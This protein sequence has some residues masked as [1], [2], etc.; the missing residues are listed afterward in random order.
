VSETLFLT[1]YNNTMVLLDTSATPAKRTELY[2]TSDASLRPIYAMPVAARTPPPIIAENTYQGERWYPE[3]RPAT[4]QI[5]NVY[6]TDSYGKLPDGVKIKSLRIVQILPKTTPLFNQP[7]LGYSS[8]N[9]AKMALGT[10]PVEDDGSVFFEA[11]IGKEIMFQVLDDKGMAVQTM[12]SGTYL[13]PGENMTCVGCHEDKLAAPPAGGTP[14]ASKRPASKMEMELGKIEPINYARTISPILTKK[15]V[16]CHQS[17]SVSP[18]DVKYSSMEPYSFWFAGDISDTVAKHGGSRSKAGA[19]GALGSRMGKALLTATH[20]KAQSDGTYTDMD[21]RTLVQWL[22]LG[23]DELGAFDNQ[24]GQRRG[25]LVW[26]SLDVDK[27]DPQ[28]LTY[29]PETPY[30]PRK[31]AGV[32]PDVGADAALATGGTSGN[33]GAGGATS[34][35]GQS[36]STSA[37]GAGG[38]AGSS[39]SSGGKTGSSGGAGGASA[40]GAG[41]SGG[42]GGSKGGQSSSSR[43]GSAGTSTASDSRS[44]SGCN[45]GTNANASQPAWLLFLAGLALV[46]RGRR[47]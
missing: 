14:A 18:T 45:V 30:V 35:G 6:V 39:A 37:G 33:T 11:P 21:A 43:G 7:R 42:S 1:S 31:D 29:T 4:V 32:S 27:N 19:I 12:R 36:G 13:H 10:V 2:K 23:S 15:C 28:G 47:R 24:D 38:S 22:D 9:V 41:A 17:K 46:L 8:E 25:D 26:P 44:S 34:K 20:Q 16:P 5:Q 3:A 40:A